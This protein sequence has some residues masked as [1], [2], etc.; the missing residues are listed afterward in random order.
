M[1]WSRNQPPHLSRDTSDRAHHSERITL[2]NRRPF[3]AES[4]LSQPPTI[5]SQDRAPLDQNP[6]FR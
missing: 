3:R 2:L 5:G 6:I 4:T 1:A